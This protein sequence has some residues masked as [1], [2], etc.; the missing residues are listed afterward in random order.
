MDTWGSLPKSQVDASTVDEQIASD[1]QDHLDD[2][3]AH[4]E[5]GQ[6]LQSHKA[7]EIIDHIAKS[8]V[9]DK[10]DDGAIS[11][12]CITGDQIIGKDFRTAADVGAGVDGVMFNGSGIEMWQDGDKKVDIP[13]SGDPTFKGA[14]KVNSLEYLRFTLQTSF[15]SLDGW[16]VTEAGVFN[17]YYHTGYLELVH[18]SGYGA[19]QEVYLPGDPYSYF[20][21]DVSKNPV[22][23][24][25]LAYDPSDSSNLYFGMGLLSYEEG[26][27]FKITAT[28]IYAVYYDSDQVM[29]TSLIKALPDSSYHRY[30]VE[31]ENGVEARFYIDGVLEKTLSWATMDL[32]TASWIPFFWS[33]ESATANA[34]SVYVLTAL[35]QQDY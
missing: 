19:M 30:R 18:D 15:E 33:I 12:R 16:Y 17:V 2:P 4:L 7:S 20:Y 13:I 31:V 5:V 8:I 23:D 3:D 6:S 24:T 29:H 21:P 32:F 1:I 14:V 25:V 28:N 27:G 11:S 35:F 10:L 9:E 34:A 26:I 22:F